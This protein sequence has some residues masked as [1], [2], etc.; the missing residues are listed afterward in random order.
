MTAQAVDNCAMTEIFSY[1]LAD[2]PL[3]SRSCATL[4][5]SRT[6]TVS[7]RSTCT[8][9]AL[10][11]KR[12]CDQS[13][14]VTW[15]YTKTNSNCH[16]PGGGGGEPID[17][18][19]VGTWEAEGQPGL[20]LNRDQQGFYG[21]YI[22]N[23]NGCEAGEGFSYTLAGEPPML[24]PPWNRDNQLVRGHTPSHGST[25]TASP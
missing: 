5:A 14:G 21:Q 6:P 15:R 12:F 22:T 8:S 19:I 2:N 18:P 3:R 7:L 17:Y 20:A 23:I 16:N 24:N 10:R 13:D 1:R 25:T 11:R 4:R 9:S